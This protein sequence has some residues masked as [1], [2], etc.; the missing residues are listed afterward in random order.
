MGWGR[1]PIALLS[2]DKLRLGLAQDLVR[3]KS[4]TRLKAKG[5]GKAKAKVFMVVDPTPLEG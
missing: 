1:D 2:L 4:L 3:S 5:K